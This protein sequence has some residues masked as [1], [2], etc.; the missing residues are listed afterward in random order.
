[1]NR[2]HSFDIAVARWSLGELTTDE[3]PRVAVDALVAGLDSSALCELAGEEAK[4]NP[5][6]SVLFDRALHELGHSRPSEDQAM[7]LNAFY[8]LRNAVAVADAILAEKIDIIEGC[9][10]IA[11]DVNR[12]ELYF[13][14]DLSLFIGIDSEA[15]DLP[16][17]PRRQQCNAEA[18]RKKDIEIARWKIAC[19]E[20]VFAARRKLIERFEMAPEMK[21]DEGK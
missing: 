21:S 20:P 12:A 11:A 2:V 15:D 3:L 1:M 4:P 5:D 7:T 6:H 17:R 10:Q 16:T 19:R 9:V 18:L 14:K 13:D 8:E